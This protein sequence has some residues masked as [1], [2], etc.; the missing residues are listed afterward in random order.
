MSDFKKV[1]Q[2]RLNHETNKV[3]NVLKNIGRKN[4]TL[5]NNLIKS[6]VRIEA[7]RFEMRTTEKRTAME[8]GRD[9]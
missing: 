8:R 2:W 1:K 6:A 4:L 5:T 3:K 9:K 7:E